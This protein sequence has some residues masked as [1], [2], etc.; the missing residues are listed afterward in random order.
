[1]SSIENYRQWYEHEKWCNEKMLEMLGSVPEGVREDERFQ[2]AVVLAA[3]LAAC[4]E[5]WLDRMIDGGV[6]QTDWWPE[7]AEL[8]DLRPRF[9]AIESRWT[10]Y[11]ANLSEP[12]LDVDFDFPVSSGGGY[13]WNI[14]G[15][16]VQLVGH[17]FYHRGQIA[18]LV[19]QLG[20][21]AVDTDYLYWA[22]S[23]KPDRWKQLPSSG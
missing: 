1:M 15:Q 4:R 14:E 6:N 5:N 13:R 23:Q 19:D 2:R 22:F 21:E 16:I 9:D 10:D 8:A 7:K 12:E 20:G 17:A 3:H 11:L 18:Q